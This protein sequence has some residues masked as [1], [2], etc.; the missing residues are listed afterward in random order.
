[1]EEDGGKPI[2]GKEYFLVDGRV[3]ASPLGVPNAISPPIL[4]S[5]RRELR[6]MQAAT[7]KKRRRGSLWQENDG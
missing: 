7:N 3:F 1:M 6:G 2:E 4:T 5:Q